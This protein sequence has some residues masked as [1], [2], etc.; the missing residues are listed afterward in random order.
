MAPMAILSFGSSASKCRIAWSPPPFDHGTASC[1]TST[2]ASFASQQ[3]ATPCSGHLLW[4]SATTLPPH[5]WQ[6]PSCLGLHFLSHPS[7]ITPH[8]AGCT[9]L[10]VATSHGPISTQESRSRQAQPHFMLRTMNSHCSSALVPS[11]FLVQ[12]SS[13]RARSHRTLWRCESTLE[14]ILYSR[15]TRTMVRVRARRRAPRLISRGMILCSFSR[16]A[17]AKARAL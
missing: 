16:L 4:T 13:T 2:H 10:G 6:T 14:R 11:F 9:C 7:L 17:R 12:I 5:V 15:C 8:R 3:R 1:R